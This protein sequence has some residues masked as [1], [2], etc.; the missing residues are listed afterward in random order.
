[1]R[2]IN[3]YRYVDGKSIIVTPVQMATADVP[4]KYRL[5]AD[6]GMVLTD[7]VDM[8]ECIDVLCENAEKWNETE[9]EIPAEEALG[10]II[11]GVNNA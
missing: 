6:E 11:G 8:T 3:L 10:I 4:Y 9:R 5:I 2:K 1:M 7:G